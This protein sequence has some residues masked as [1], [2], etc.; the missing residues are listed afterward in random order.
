MINNLANYEKRKET[1]HGHTL[2]HWGPDES[3][4]N[5]H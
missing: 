2:N 3:F 4:R 1:E 5:T